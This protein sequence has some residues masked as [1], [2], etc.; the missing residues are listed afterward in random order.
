MHII[1]HINHIVEEMAKASNVK[2]VSRE[3]KVKINMYMIVCTSHD[4]PNKMK[5]DLA[6]TNNKSWPANVQ[7]L[8]IKAAVCKSCMYA[9][10]CKCKEEH[11]NMNG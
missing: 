8:D 7:G 5:H 4:N 2:V 11:L 6:G 9:C 3:M 10:I 1:N